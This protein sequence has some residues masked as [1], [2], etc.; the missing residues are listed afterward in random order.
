MIAW[1]NFAVL[2]LAS[3]LF[4]YFYVLSVSPA[5]R[6]KVLGPGVYA[7]CMRERIVAGIFMGITVVNYVIYVFY[8]LPTPLTEK[9]PW[10]WWISAL[11]AA[12]IGIPAMTLMFIGTRHAGEETMR[13]KKE[14]TMYRGIYAKIRHPQAAGEVFGW[15]VIAL[16][17]HSPFLAVLSLIYFPI[18]LLMCFAEEQD[19]LWR[20]GDAY[21]EYCKSTGAFCPNKWGI[22]KRG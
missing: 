1:I 9:F 6:E 21:A 3:L 16:L 13:P 2:I 8:P 22:G 20:Y 10:S 18:F 12:V 4:L 7:R 11:L 14:H 15:L 5:T 19:L 17:L